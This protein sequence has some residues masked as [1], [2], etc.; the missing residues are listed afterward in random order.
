MKP[1]L[2]LLAVISVL[3]STNNAL[4][5]QKL[6]VDSVK[7]NT[8]G[9]SVELSF[10]MDI[11][12]GTIK[13]NYDLYYIPVLIQENKELQFPAI[14]LSGSR[15]QMSNARKSV[16]NSEISNLRSISGHEGTVDYTGDAP[17]QRW[18]SQHDSKLAF[19]IKR[20]GYQRSTN[21]GRFFLE[22]PILL[23]HP[24]T[25]WTPPLSG[26]DTTTVTGTQ[27]LYARASLY[28]NDGR[29]AEATQM[30]DS[31][32]SREMRAAALTGI[33]RIA[34]DSALR[35]AIFP[36]IGLGADGDRYTLSLDS[37]P[38]IPAKAWDTV[39]VRL[40]F[41]VK[42]STL[43][44][45]MKSKL[46]KIIQAVASEEPGQKSH[47][48][49]TGAASPEGFESLNQKLAIGRAGAIQNYLLEQFKLKG[50]NYPA[51]KIH[52]TSL[53]SDWEGLYQLVDSSDMPYREEVL[54]LLRTTPE[55]E[56]R[57]ALWALKWGV[58]YTYLYKHTFPK[59]RG[60]TMVSLLPGTAP[61]TVGQDINQAIELIRKGEYAS[62]RNMLL[63]Y[64]EDPRATF[65]FAIA[66]AM[67]GDFNMLSI[68]SSQS[69][70][71]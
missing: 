9:A 4:F 38:L 14:A 3:L 42:D 35:T 7:I 34:A 61:D 71:E 19:D 1:F 54:E 33:W 50:I 49:I 66:C 20:E 17:Y 23:K 18:L 44:Q 30:L 69:A 67:S 59:L 37:L 52:I 70:T 22:D 15:K 12:K 32:A 2:T 63:P 31:L 27:L 57:H 55:A 64:A 47:I 68:L 48:S 56:R 53:G 13:Q 8:Q 45:N 21:L 36:K 62:A 65:P 41:P 25:I 43:D 60:A 11:P 39:A 10:Q 5:A 26:L 46:D 40:L 58:P 28:G 6:H 29:Y 51:E 16:M 24:W